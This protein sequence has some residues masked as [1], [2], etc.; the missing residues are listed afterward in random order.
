MWCQQ[1]LKL[2]LGGLLRKIRCRTDD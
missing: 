2:R 1:N